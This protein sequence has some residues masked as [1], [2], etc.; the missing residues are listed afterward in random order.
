MTH[1]YK[2]LSIGRFPL[3]GAKSLMCWVALAGMTVACL[4]RNTARSIG[5]NDWRATGGDPG[6]SRYSALDQINRANVASLRV[7]WRYHA[8][9]VAAD[10]RSE[11]QATP[12]VVDGVLYTTTPALAV[13]AL[14]ADS[15]M[16]LWR[17]DPFANRVRESHVNRG[18]AFWSEGSERRIFFSAGRRLYSLDATTGRPAPNFGDSGWVDLSAGLGRA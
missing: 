5:T 10:S 15:G 6:N 11:I 14:R 16:L 18:V 8:G 17:F 12:V 7:A 13:V 9:D 2:A 1:H 4:G 3:T